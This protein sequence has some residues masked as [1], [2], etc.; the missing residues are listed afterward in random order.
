[1]DSADI[2]KFIHDMRNSL[3]TAN[4]NIMHLRLKG[5]ADE[6]VLDRLDVALAEATQ[7]LAKLE[8]ATQTN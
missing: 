3:N 7:L 8:M 1:M 2:R 4:I 6:V 5:S